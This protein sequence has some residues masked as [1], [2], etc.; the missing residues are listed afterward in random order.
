[1]RTEEN[2]RSKGV[3]KRQEGM[4]KTGIGGRHRWELLGEDARQVGHGDRLIWINVG[5]VDIRLRMEYR[6]PCN[7]HCKSTIARSSQTCFSSS[8]HPP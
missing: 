4:R 6:F 5:I 8:C 1:M 3:L 7:K 2:G